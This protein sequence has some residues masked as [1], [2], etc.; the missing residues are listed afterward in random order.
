[1]TLTVSKLLL[2]FTKTEEFNIRNIVNDNKSMANSHDSSSSNLNSH[3][4]AISKSIPFSFT[5]QNKLDDNEDNATKQKSN[6]API[7]ELLD[8]AHFNESEYDEEIKESAISSVVS[9]REDDVEELND[10]LSKID[11]EEDEPLS[12]IENENNLEKYVVKFKKTDQERKAS[13]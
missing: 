4:A 6:L 2:L 7:L 13:E 1:M 10:L 11:E 8:K 5:T 12:D 3:N 9:K